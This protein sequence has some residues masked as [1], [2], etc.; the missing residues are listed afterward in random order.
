MHS[1]PLEDEAHFDTKML[2]EEE[3]LDQQDIKDST[4]VINTNFDQ[5][6]HR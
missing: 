1:G 3:Y 4:N 6:S 5:N 2:T